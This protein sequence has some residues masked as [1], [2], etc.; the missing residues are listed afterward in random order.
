MFVIDSHCDSIQ[1]AEPVVNPLNHGYNFSNKYPHL[2]FV[3]MFCGWPKEDSKACYIRATRYLGQY[4]LALATEDLAPVTKFADLEKAFA[5]G[6]NATLLSVEGATGYK[7]SV[8]IFR[9]FY[10]AGVRVTGLYW[11]SNDLAMSNRV[12]SPEE[13]TG[14]TDAGRAIVE[15]GNKL[16]MIFDVSHM[17]DKS[18]WDVAALSKKPIV[19]SHSNFRSLASHS[20]N[21]TDDMAKEIIRQGGMIGLNLCTAFVDDHGEN[22]T[23][24]RLFDHL[25][26]CIELGGIDCIGFGGDID[27]ID[28]LPAPLNFETSIHDQIIDAMKVRGYSDELIEKVAWKNWYNYLKKNLD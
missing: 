15:E 13:D 12:E 19:A 6:R 1:K 14:L 16:G 18:F 4:Q 27:G 23:V 20:R 21:L 26:H 25:D 9:A 10:Q 24:E 8:D 22:Q 17:S 7:G 28:G 5:E 11:L 3:A 2:Q